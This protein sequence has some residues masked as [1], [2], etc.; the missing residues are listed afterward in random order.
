MT[1]IL[2]LNQGESSYK[3]W[4]TFIIGDTKYRLKKQEYR[5]YLHNAE[6]KEEPERLFQT[7]TN[8]YMIRRLP[9]KLALVVDDKTARIE[10]FERKLHFTRN[11]RRNEAND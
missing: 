8:T 7:G 10:P 6:Y 3:R 1:S 5:A 9:N 2:T 11:W 4:S